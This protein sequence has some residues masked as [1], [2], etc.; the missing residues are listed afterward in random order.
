MLQLRRPKSGA[1]TVL[2]MLLQ[3][4]LNLYLG[5]YRF[6]VSYYENV[7]KSTK[8]FAKIQF[9]LIVLYSY[10]KIRAVVFLWGQNLLYRAQGCYSDYH[11]IFTKHSSWELDSVRK[12]WDV[13]KSK[14]FFTFQTFLTDS[15][16]FYTKMCKLVSFCAH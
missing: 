12:E 2:P 7:S 1:K 16:E 9:C 4:T 10:F 14:L 13:S 3:F 5:L 11:I 8:V 6:T 15:N